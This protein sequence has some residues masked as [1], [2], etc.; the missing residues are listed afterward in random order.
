MA[1]LNRY[2]P[3][4]FEPDIV[5]DPTTF[6]EAVEA[7][8]G[9]RITPLVDAVRMGVRYG[10]V[11]PDPDFNPLENIEGYEAYATSFARAVNEQQQAEIKRSIDLSIERRQVQANATLTVNTLSGLTDPVN[12]F[13]IPLGGPTTSFLRSAARSALNVGGVETIAETAG[14]A[15]D[16]VKTMSEAALNVA[17]AS[18]FGGAIGGGLSIPVARRAEAFEKTQAANQELFDAAERIELLN[19]MTADEIMNAG[20]REGRLFNDLEDAEISDRIRKMEQDALEFERQGSSDLAEN[21]RAESVAMK[22]ELGI[23]KVEELGIDLTDPFNIKGSWFTDSIFFKAI[24]TPLKRILQSKYPSKVK[25]IAARGFADGGFSLVQNSVGIPSTQSVLLRSSV[26]NGRWVE[27][28][29]ALTK[30]WAAETGA[31][32]V[33]RLDLSASKIGRAISRAPNTYKQW[34]EM[35]SEKR[36]KGDPNMS[37]NELK[38][39]SIM[40]EYF[41]GSQ[42]KLE[43]AGLI[44]S[45]KG[46]QRRLE[47][48]EA[49]IAD[50]ELKLNSVGKNTEAG[51]LS[52]DRLKKLREDYKAASML[53]KE[54]D[55]ISSPDPWF[56]IFY[57][58]KVIRA[59]R[60][61]FSKVL[62]NHFKENPYIYKI[63]DGKSQKVR[64]STDPEQIQKRVDDA[65]NRILNEDDPTSLESVSFGAGRSKHFRSRQLNIPTR[66]ISDFIIK[67]PIAVMKTYGARIEPRYAFTKEFGKELDGVRFE[68]EYE[69]IKAGHSRDEINKALRD[70]Q[71]LYDAVAGRMLERPDALS[72][73]VATF[74]RDAATV[75]YLG[76]AG[77]AAIPDFGRIVLEHGLEDV[78]KGIQGLL[79]RERVSMTVDEV[80]KAGEAI[81]ILKGS[82]QLRMV[83]DLSNNIEA[84][85]IWTTAKNAFFVLNG[86]GPVTTLSKQLAGIVEAHSII[87]N[88][89]KLSSGQLD[90]QMIERLAKQ[91]IGVEDAR[92]IASMPYEK[93][94]NNLF[95]ANTDAWTDINVEDVLEELRPKFRQSKKRVTEM[96]EKE[97]VRRFQ[98]EFFFDRVIT[99]EKIVEDVMAKN[100]YPD[101]LG[102]SMPFGDKPNTIYLNLNK[103]KQSFDRFKSATGKQSIDELRAKLDAARER[104]G[105][106]AY[107]HKIKLLD[108]VDLFD[109]ADDF[110]EFILLHELHHTTNARFQG[111]SLVEYE[112]RIDDLTFDYI[113]NQRERGLRL[114]AEKEAGKR[115]AER[116][117]LVLKFRTALNSGVASTVISGSPADKPIIVSG[118]AYVPMSVG[119]KFGMKEHPKYPGYA[120]IEN[121]LM[122][123]PFQFYNF[124]LG[125]I[126]KTMAPIAHG[127]VKSRTVGLATM[128]GLAYMSLSLRTPDYV[129][130][131]MSWQ[132]RFVRSVDMS[133]IVA[134]YSDMMYTSM[135][136]SLALGGPNITAGLIQPKFNQKESVA[137]A[138]TGLAGAGP[139]WGYDTASG[140]VSFLSGDYGQ[141]AKDIVRNLPFARMWFLKDDINQITNSWAN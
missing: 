29:D 124:A 100:G 52:D 132:D 115:I 98:D 71:H 15:F 45:P 86:L 50:V 13:A 114:A 67:D 7:V 81:D 87:E 97:L 43:G 53:A 85:E 96:N 56:P 34:L 94:E 4:F 46:I 14:L 63:K 57:N 22:Q 59:R 129:W 41:E 58:Q 117:D 109:D 55:D 111:E 54:P 135:H 11:K 77:L 118:V 62:Y 119:K 32:T 84:N 37:E 68:I 61:D 72:Q 66:L 69:M 47:L 49:E 21:I 16:P 134:L 137:D 121:G 139:S 126:N 31:S 138:I 23:R 5:P 26:A 141:G 93:T 73:K 70:F 101:G 112:A 103:I 42:K 107:V 64:L 130:D 6:G 106:E 9:L 116:E 1:D 79:D 20:P 120:R 91:G 80:R 92:L 136:T 2:S 113:R 51:R 27:A 74:L 140:I 65:I 10:N 35:V 104:I 125:A 60:E 38:A 44:A 133:G 131:K 102:Y 88:S 24:S 108:N 123:L 128:M 127:Q 89:I 25:E 3:A 39:A 28:D 110:A 76:G 78:A 83:E 90:D 40:N 99:D 95:I 18:I 48:L 82:A 122:G 17:A 12:L 8:Q 30:I 36:I 19:G 105:D 33:S 75:N